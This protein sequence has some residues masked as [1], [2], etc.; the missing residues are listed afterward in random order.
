MLDGGYRCSV[1]CNDDVA[2]AMCVVDTI[3]E[4]GMRS[5]DAAVEVGPGRSLHR[6]EKMDGWG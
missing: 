5:A 2:L 3:T 6:S 4:W 1:D